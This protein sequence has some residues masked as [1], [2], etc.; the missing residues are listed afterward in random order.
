[1]LKIS[2]VDLVQVHLPAHAG[3]WTVLAEILHDV[4]STH[5]VPC[6][7]VTSKLGKAEMHGWY[8]DLPLEG[9][10]LEVGLYRCCSRRWVMYR[11]KEAV[12]VNAFEEV[13]APLAEASLVHAMVKGTVK[14]LELCVDFAGL[15]SS[16]YVLHRKGVRSS[17]VKKNALQ[18][19]ISQY[20]G[21]P[22]ALLQAVLYDKGEEIRDKGGKTSFK[23]LL[24]FELR[25]R[26]RKASL[27]KL[28]HEIGTND[29]FAGTYIVE[30][31]AVLP[32]KTKIASW[33]V[34]VS[35]CGIF[36]VAVALRLF[37]SHKETFLK[38]LKGLNVKE[39]VPCGRDFLPILALLLPPNLVSKA[40]NDP[41]LAPFV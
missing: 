36:G 28:M 2:N 16:D 25:L 29:P 38:L 41:P 11:F 15:K 6:K 4:A 5:G 18:T 17:S 14:V 27:M 19:G 37:K 31:K 9:E 7:K 3:I 8:V 13:L 26:N 23:H 1:M 40:L 32:Q 12:D 30:L 10:R 20:S 21:S 34:F 33:G 39:L 24:R 35:M 22:G